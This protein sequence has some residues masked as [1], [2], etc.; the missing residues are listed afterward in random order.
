[1]ISFPKPV[2]SGNFSL[3]FNTIPLREES[4]YFNAMFGS[5]FLETTGIRDVS[6]VTV[7]DGY[8][9]DDLGDLIYAN[10]STR[11]EQGQELD[12]SIS[13]QIYHIIVT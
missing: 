2:G 10:R 4:E 12:K 8:D 7:D 1:L 13:S 11:P 5:D 6:D 9:S 3:W